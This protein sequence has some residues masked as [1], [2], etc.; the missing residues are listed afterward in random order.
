MRFLRPSQDGYDIAHRVDPH[1]S[2]V[3]LVQVHQHVRLNTML[4]E[5]DG[6]VLGHGLR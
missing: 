6:V 1:L 4:D 3:L 2:Q 5:Y